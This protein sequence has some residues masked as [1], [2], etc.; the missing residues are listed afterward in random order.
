MFAVL[1]VNLLYQFWIHSEFIPKL[2]WF[3]LVLNSPSNHRV[4]HASNPVYFDKNYGGVTMIFDHMFASYQRELDAEP[5]RYGLVH[6]VGA[7]LTPTR[8]DR[9]D[10]PNSRKREREP[11]ERAG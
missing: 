3:D 1:L 2:G 9:S 6:A 4:H 10:R 5:C 8:A 11:E 7:T